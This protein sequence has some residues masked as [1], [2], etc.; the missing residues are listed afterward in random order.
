MKEKQ[1]EEILF[2]DNYVCINACQSCYNVL[3]REERNN[4]DKETKECKEKCKDQVT[5]KK[6][7]KSVQLKTLR[8][9]NNKVTAEINKK[10]E[11]NRSQIKE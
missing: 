2:T 7:N 11:K 5:A 3:I 6:K 9:N 8:I 10:R 1:G 4:V